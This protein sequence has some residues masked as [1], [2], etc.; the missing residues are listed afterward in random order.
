MKKIKAGEI[1]KKEK[2]IINKLKDRFKYDIKKM[3]TIVGNYDIDSNVILHQDAIMKAYCYYA[4]TQKV[5]GRKEIMG[6]LAGK[7]NKDKIEI[8]DAYVGDCKSSSVYTNLDPR[9]TVRMMNMAKENGLQLVGQWHC[10]P[11][12]SVHPSP[13][14]TDTMR[15]L[16][17]F[18]MKKP[19][20]IIVN[21]NKFWLGTINNNFMQ[22]VDF[23]IPAKT[24][25]EFS[26]NLGYINGEHTP[27]YLNYNENILP[28]ADDDWLAYCTMVGN[29]FLLGVDFFFPFLNLKKWVEWK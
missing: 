13:E 29:F 15:T 23:V 11:G 27:S 21:S 5:Q 6:W 12:M 4:I 10:H 18:G 16:K 7:I 17:A 1:K 24:D 26:I 14:D 22:K 8:V 28:Y 2:G 3:E 9:H 19:I 20:M 25:N